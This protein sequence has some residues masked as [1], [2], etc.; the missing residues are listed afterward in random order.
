VKVKLAPALALVVMLAGCVPTPL[1]ALL[2]SQT[3]GSTPSQ[4]ALPDEA[5]LILAPGP[6]S[7]L[8]EQVHVEGVAD[9]TFEQT[10]VLQLVALGGDEP[11]ILVQEPVMIQAELGQRG[12]FATDIDLSLAG[13]SE[14]PGQVNVFSTSPRDGGVTH[15]ASVP[16][17]LAPNGS[18]DVRS[19][20]EHPEQVV[21]TSPSPGAVVRGGRAHVEGIGLASFEQNLVA[22]VY[23]AQGGLIGRA[24]MTVSAPEYGV[25][26]P[27]AGD[28]PYQLSVAGPG[29]IVVLDPSPAFG[30]TLHLASVEVQIE[31]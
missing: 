12:E 16:V 10:L 20:E 15:L 4:E 11:K 6:G 30:Q 7:R 1:G 28:V 21:I 26:G 3:A 14:Q 27:F 19:A 13:A 9:S 17:T 25:A 5:I 29:R 24:P 22:E 23:D 18:S 2:P 8:V 31:P